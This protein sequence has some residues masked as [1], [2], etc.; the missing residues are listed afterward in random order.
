MIRPDSAPPFVPSHS[1]SSHPSMGTNESEIGDTIFI[2]QVRQRDNS[3]S[4]ACGGVY[5]TSGMQL[6]TSDQAAGLR[7]KTNLAERHH[8]NR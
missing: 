3:F 4:V 8:L 6:P 5:C 1:A 7:R 2:S